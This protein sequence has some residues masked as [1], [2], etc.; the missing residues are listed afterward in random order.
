MHH[1]HPPF[2][3]DDDDNDDWRD[4]LTA[5]LGWKLDLA[6]EIGHPHCVGQ[7]LFVNGMLGSLHRVFGKDAVHRI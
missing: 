6:L 5:P 4:S 2:T 3:D 1:Y 7:A